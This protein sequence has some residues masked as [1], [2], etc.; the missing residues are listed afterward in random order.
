MRGSDKIL[1]D[2]RT[3]EM[4]ATYWQSGDAL[5][6]HPFVAE[7]MNNLPKIVVSKSLSK[8]EWHNSRIFSDQIPERVAELKQQAGGGDTHGLRVC[9]SGRR[10]GKAKK[11]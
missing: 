3:D 8:L 1:W 9:A 5:H 6:S 2:Y 7:R 10:G 4:M 11:K